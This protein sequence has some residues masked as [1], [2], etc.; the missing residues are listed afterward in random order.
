MTEFFSKLIT[1]SRTKHREIA[2][3]QERCAKDALKIFRNNFNIGTYLE[4]YEKLAK[5]PNNIYF[6]RGI[7]MDVQTSPKI[8]IPSTILIKICDFLSLIMFLY[9]LLS[10]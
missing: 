3:N 2:T 10:Y 7:P 1:L 8:L 4:I 5:T 6:I 9:P